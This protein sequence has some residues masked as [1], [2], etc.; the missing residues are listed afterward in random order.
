[1][2]LQ[3]SVFIA[4]CACVAAVHAAD[5]K[6]P[7]P[8]KNVPES[9]PI[10]ASLEGDDTSTLDLGGKTAAEFE[11]L[12]KSESAL[13]KGLPK[14]P[15]VKLKLVLKNTAD[16]EI[17]IFEKGDPITVELAL[18]GPGVL[19]VAPRLA[20]TMEF[21]MPVA[22]KLAPGKTLEIPLTQLASGKRG[23]GTYHYWTKP[24]DYELVATFNTSINPA[25]KDAKAG[26]DGFAKVALSTAGFKL[27][28]GEKKK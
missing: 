21:R 1:M 13:D 18:T 27:T 12:L 16:T 7:T 8:A 9:T 6:K 20:M 15:A 3:I 26:R 10:T 14:P 25:P 11:A 24:G 17:R 19:S 2:H 22:V 28:V 5:G 4:L 23:A